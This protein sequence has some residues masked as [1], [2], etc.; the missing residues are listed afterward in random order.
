VELVEQ[1][2]QAAAES[3][4][5]CSTTRSNEAIVIGFCVALGTLLLGSTGASAQPEE[6]AFSVGETEGGKRQRGK[7]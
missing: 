7:G 5:W 4:A 3:Q 1:L 6:E 2:R